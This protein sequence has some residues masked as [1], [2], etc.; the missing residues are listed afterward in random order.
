M[1]L[2]EKQLRIS[3]KRGTG[4]TDL[5]TPGPAVAYDRY[6]NEYLVVWQGDELG[7]E[8]YE[9]WGQ[10]VNAT[11]GA[12]AGTDPRLSDA[13]TRQ[14]GYNQHKSGGEQVGNVRP[15][16]KGGGASRDNRRPRFRLGQIGIT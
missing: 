5:D 8:E 9:T 13:K 10:R 7:V 12:Q 11:S 4:N 16:R 2:G 3:D 15:P 1:R 14:I 6:N